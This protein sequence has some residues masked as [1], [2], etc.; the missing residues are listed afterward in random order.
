MLF[1]KFQEY[2]GFILALNDAVKGKALNSECFISPAVEKTIVMLTK[3]DQW[4]TDIPPT[5]QPQRFGN[6][7]FRDWHKKLSEVRHI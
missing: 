6:K 1:I 2:L 5:E 3:F 4:I 7:S